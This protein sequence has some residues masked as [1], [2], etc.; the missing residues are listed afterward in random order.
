MRYVTDA[1]IAAV[2]K[3]ATARICLAIEGALLTALRRGDLLRLTRANLKDE[4]ILV[5]TSKTGVPLLIEWSDALRA[6]TDRARRLKPQ[7]P[8]TYLI[9]TRTGQFYTTQGFSANWKRTMQK[10]VAREGIEPF[11]FQD[12][13][14]K[15]SDDSADEHEAQA[16][17]G[18]TNVSTT[19]RHYR[20]KPN[21]VRPLR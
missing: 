3:H 18:H 20:T 19:R 12:I 4:G 1:E 11:T 6:W 16:R 5:R 8:G 21:R 7:V 14:R 15:S 17:L 10:A 2:R 13:R 9:R